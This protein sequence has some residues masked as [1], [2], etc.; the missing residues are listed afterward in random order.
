MLSVTSTPVE[1]NEGFV[2]VVPPTKRNQ[3]LIVFGRVQPWMSV[4]I[5]PGSYSEPS[6]FFYCVRSAH[7]MMR[8]MGYNLQRGN[9]LNFRRGR[10]G[11]LWTFVPK[12]KPV[13]YYDKTCRG[14]GYIT[15][16]IQSQS[17]TALP[18]H[19]SSSSEWES[20][21]SVRVVFKNLFV[22][23]TSINQLEQEEVLKLLT[24]SHGPSNLISSE[25]SDLN[26]N[27]TLKIR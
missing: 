13:D 19:S 18:S 3:S 25:R 8:R 10:R 2:F 27:R 12:G 16:P 21:V 9:G 5:D 4:V 26:V 1:N 22:N 7:K 6:Q 24:L 23:V 17:E 14:L 15:P 11:L 20:D